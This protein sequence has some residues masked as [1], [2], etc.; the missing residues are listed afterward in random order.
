MQTF[1][2]RLTLNKEQES[3]ISGL[4][5][6]HSEGVRH[7]MSANY[8]QGK[9]SKTTYAE[10][11]GLGLT[12]CQSSSAQN[13]AEMI[14]KRQLEADKYQKIKSEKR[15][16]YA[17]KNL[18]RLELRLNKKNIAENSIKLLR[19]KIAMKTESLKLKEK[20]LIILTN[21]LS[22]NKVKI[23]FGSRTLLKQNPKINP[24]SIYKNYESWRQEWNLRRNN[25]VV[26]IGKKNVTLGNP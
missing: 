12:A 23:C 18:S 6:A 17:K 8:R 24:D 10:L 1:E 9:D 7:A 5:V 15:L 3:L 11:I 4:C 26:S 19:Q 13:I 25:S 20:N 2:T 16:L 21:R 22:K 14:F